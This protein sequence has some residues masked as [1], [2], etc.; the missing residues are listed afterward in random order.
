VSKFSHLKKKDITSETTAWCPLYGIEMNGRVP[1][2]LL[3]PA[4]ECN[5][6]YYNATLRRTTARARVTQAK[7][8]TAA[9]MKGDRDEDRELFPKF[10]VR[11]W[12]NVV[13]DEG[14]GVDFNVDNCTAFLEALPNHVFD[15]ARNFASNASYFDGT[16]NAEDGEAVAGN[17]PSASSS[18]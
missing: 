13:D 3:A 11:D 12:K 17:S 8:L 14:K 1:E 9:M 2:L 18:S 16:Y 15:V 10:V 6:P 5:E 4:L 7:G